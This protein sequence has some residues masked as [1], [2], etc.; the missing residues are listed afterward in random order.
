VLK[1]GQEISRRY[2]GILSG[3]RGGAELP[4]YLAIPAEERAWIADLAVHN[5]A[6]AIRTGEKRSFMTYCRD[7]A[8]RR[9]QQGIRVSEMVHALRGLERVCLE[10]LHRDPEAKDLDRAM[11]DYV[12]MTV[13]FGIDQVVEA[14]EDAALGSGRESV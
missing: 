9:S 5:L 13:E 4:G 8:E 10:I 2:L 7:F 1:H 14:Y 3:G 6:Q 11:R 12:S